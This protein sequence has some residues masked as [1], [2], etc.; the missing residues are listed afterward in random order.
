MEGLGTDHLPDFVAN[1]MMKMSDIIQEKKLNQAL[2]HCFVWF[3]GKNIT[4]LR[5]LQYSYSQLLDLLKFL[6]GR[7]DEAGLQIYCD[8]LLQLRNAL[9]IASSGDQVLIAGDIGRLLL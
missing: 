5:V 8:S 1:L 9:T 4:V 2:A 3:L 7:L 6:E